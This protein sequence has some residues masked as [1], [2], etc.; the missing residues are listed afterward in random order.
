[1]NNSDT[2]HTSDEIESKCVEIDMLR[3]ERATTLDDYV[4]WEIY[5]HSADERVD[6]IEDRE[7]AVETAGEHDGCMYGL[8][9]GDGRLDELSTER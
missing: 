6:I 8:R 9:E 3:E 1:M 5:D 2:R 7:E 4:A